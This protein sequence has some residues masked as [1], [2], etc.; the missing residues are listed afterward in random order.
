M[1]KKPQYKNIESSNLGEPYKSEGMRTFLIV[2]GF[3]IMVGVVSFLSS[4]GITAII[5]K[6]LGHNLKLF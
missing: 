5:M 2:S 4:A 1:R 6:L 3:I